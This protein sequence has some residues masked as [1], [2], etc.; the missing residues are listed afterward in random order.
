LSANRCLAHGLIPPSPA[1]R[2][3]I[4]VDLEGD[5]GDMTPIFERK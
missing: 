3:S 1:V 4:G 2:L 5:R